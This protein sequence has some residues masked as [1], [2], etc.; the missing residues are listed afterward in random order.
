MMDEE[1]EVQLAFHWY[2]VAQCSGRCGISKQVNIHKDGT[3]FDS[4]KTKAS[5]LSFKETRRKAS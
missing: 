2:K 3:T 5:S 1:N 4:D